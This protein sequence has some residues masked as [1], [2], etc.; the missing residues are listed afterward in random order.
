MPQP[1]YNPLENKM[2]L[3]KQLLGNAFKWFQSLPEHTHEALSTR[4]AQQQTPISRFVLAEDLGFAELSAA[5]VLLLSEASCKI[6][7]FCNQ[8]ATNNFFQPSRALG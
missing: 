8:A 6:L 3:R 4:G 5:R 7:T 1:T 2:S